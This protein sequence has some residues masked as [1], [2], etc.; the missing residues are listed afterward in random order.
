[1]QQPTSY[2]LHTFTHKHKQR[3]RTACMRYIDNDIWSQEIWNENISRNIIVDAQKLLNL[4]K[5]SFSLSLSCSVSLTKHQKYEHIEKLSE[6]VVVV[7]VVCHFSGGV[8][9]VRTLSKHIFILYTTSGYYKWNQYRMR[10]ANARTLFDCC[11]CCCFTPHSTSRHTTHTER[12]A[13]RTAYQFHGMCE[14]VWWNDCYTYF[15]AHFVC[16]HNFRPKHKTK[17]KNKKFFISFASMRCAYE[18]FGRLIVCE[19]AS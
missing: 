8:S 15:R 10:I 13:N 3:V 6:L 19:A 18:F 14:C 9:S 11:W 2:N 4:Y 5:I 12:I 17:L 16:A 1:M 7:V